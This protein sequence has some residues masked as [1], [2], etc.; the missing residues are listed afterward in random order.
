MLETLK[1]KLTF[2]DKIIDAEDDIFAGYLV[3]YKSEKD[4]QKQADIYKCGIRELFLESI[5]DNKPTNQQ[6]DNT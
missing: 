1:K 3:V 4:A 6:G 5:E 2:G